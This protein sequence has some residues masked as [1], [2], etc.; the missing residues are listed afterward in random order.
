MIQTIDEQ[1]DK[2][3]SS[4]P[5]INDSQIISIK[6]RSATTLTDDLKKGHAT[7]NVCM[8]A[9]SILKQNPKDLAVKLASIMEKSKKYEKSDLIRNLPK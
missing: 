3:L 1:I 7:S 6:E 5:E 2:F 9:A 8:I 4:L